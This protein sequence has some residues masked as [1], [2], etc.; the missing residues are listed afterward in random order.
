MKRADRFAL[1]VRDA[2]S[3]LLANMTDKE[4]GVL[5][6][7]ILG[8]SYGDD[9]ELLALHTTIAQEFSLPAEATVT[10][11]AVLIVKIECGATPQ[12]G[13]RAT[14]RKAGGAEYAVSF[15]DVV[16]PESSTGALF[17]RVYRSWLDVPRPTRSRR[18]LQRL[19]ILESKARVGQL[20]M[21]K[22]IELVLLG[23][24]S[25]HGRCRVLET[26]KDLTLRSVEVW[27]LV[28]GEIVVVKPSKHWSYAGHPYI[29]GEIQ[30][31]R[32]DV[33]A[34]CLQPLGLQEHGIWEQSE[35][36]GC[37]EDGTPVDE[38]ERSD[39]K[40]VSRMAYEME[41]I[42][43]TPP[44]HFVEEDAIEKA[45]EL[46]EAGDIGEA[47]RVLMGLTLADLRCLDAHAHLGNLEFDHKTERALRHYDVGRRIGELSFGP[48]FSGVLPW[49]MIGNRPYLRC[50]HGYGRC[51]WRLN[52]CEE[53]ANVFT[54][55]LALCPADD[56]R[57]RDLLLDVRTGR[58]CLRMRMQTG[59]SI[60]GHRLLIAD[61]TLPETS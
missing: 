42:I 18:S 33:S 50:L 35:V 52:R 53:A 43:P 54:R 7:E 37:G 13:L 24:K 31:H 48:G 21:H 61:A 36:G 22:P 15:A 1:D 11:E 19:K 47:E 59:S 34:L 25:N 2:L 9:E 14:C 23:I 29:T 44:V 60:D 58:S 57:V 38:R 4:T 49:N 28:P 46:A 39:L 3:M 51:L 45:I 8:D 41:M 32:I 5:L 17:V 56:L 30:S 55:M 40:S 16:F 12:Q 6:E 26:G 20:E 10:G 27:D